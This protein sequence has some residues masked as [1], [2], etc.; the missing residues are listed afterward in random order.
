MGFYGEPRRGVAVILAA[1]DVDGQLKVIGQLGSGLAGKEPTTRYKMLSAQRSP[2]P[3]VTVKATDRVRWV[4]P[5]LIAEVAYRQYTARGGLR[6]SA[7][8]GLRAIADEGAFY[9][10]LAEDS[11]GPD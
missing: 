11:D 5:N 4:V 8:K 9:P 1:N 3:V 10:L 6:H 7:W 2:I